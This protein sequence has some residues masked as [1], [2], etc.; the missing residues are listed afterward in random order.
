MSVDLPPN[1]AIKIYLT[2]RTQLDNYQ[3][4]G[5]PELWR[6]ARRGLQINVLQAEQ[7]IESEVSPNRF[8]WKSA[9][10]SQKK[11]SGRP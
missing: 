2:Y 5:I 3:V 4:L 6:Y 9:R 8:T 1:L 10:T 7:Y 11:H